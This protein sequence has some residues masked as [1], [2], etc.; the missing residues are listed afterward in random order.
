VE[1]GGGL[2]RIRIVENQR[3]EENLAADRG[4]EPDKI[5][6][7]RL[8]SSLLRMQPFV[9]GVKTGYWHVFPIDNPL[10]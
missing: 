10:T 7:F 8:I 2:W 4:Q 5:W 6:H 1:S 3:S 9:S